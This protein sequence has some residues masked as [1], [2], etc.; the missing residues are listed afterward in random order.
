MKTP[1][2][3]TLLPD[4]KER[5]ILQICEEKKTQTK[6]KNIKFRPK[7]VELGLLCCLSE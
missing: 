7:F 2:P 3:P 1:P 4:S 5:Q 6:T